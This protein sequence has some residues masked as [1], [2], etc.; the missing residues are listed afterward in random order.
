MSCQ[1]C[2]GEHSTMACD[3]VTSIRPRESASGGWGPDVTCNGILREALCASGSGA[4]P[5]VLLAEAEALA[6]A[7]ETFA[8]GDDIPSV[9]WKYLKDALAA[10]R[11]R[12][13]AQE[14]TK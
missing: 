2:G 12:H 8:R 9:A 1:K 6:E 10:F 13:P 14:V 4:P 7:I 3:E 5:V 11:S